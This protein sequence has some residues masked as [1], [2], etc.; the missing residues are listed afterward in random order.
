MPEVDPVT[1]ATGRSD[2]PIVPLLRSLPVTSYRTPLR[3]SSV[4]RPVS[5]APIVNGMTPSDDMMV[6]DRALVRRRRD[7][8]APGLGEHG[9][10]FD[11][12][13]AMLADRLLDVSRRFPR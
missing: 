8:A 12:V 10:L 5:P 11:H 3:R 4:S 1:R 6:F 2:M 13:A 9:F 7:R